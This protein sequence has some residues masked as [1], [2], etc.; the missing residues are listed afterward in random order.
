MV[1]FSY[2]CGWRAAVAASLDMVFAESTQVERRASQNLYAEGSK[3]AWERGPPPAAAERMVVS[4]ADKVTM[5]FSLLLF[6]AKWKE[7]SKQMPFLRLGEGVR[8]RTLPPRRPWDGLLLLLLAVVLGVLLRGNLGRCR[9]G[10][11]L[12]VVVVVVADS[13][14][15][16]WGGEWRGGV[17]L[18]EVV[19]KGT[20]TSSRCM[21]GRS[22]E[23]EAAASQTWSWISGGRAAKRWN[24]DGCIML[25]GSDCTEW[26]CTRDGRNSAPG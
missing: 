15:P 7:V 24:L 9:T 4:R 13:S 11:V 18:V 26:S 8:F 3:G 16:C 1:V 14:R 5:L 20:F 2:E 19:G 25:E 23:D 17:A 21:A 10:I 12:V 22:R 6:S